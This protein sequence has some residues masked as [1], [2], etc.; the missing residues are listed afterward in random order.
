MN[1]AVRTEHGSAVVFDVEFVKEDNFSRTKAIR[2]TIIH[3]D[4]IKPHDNM[5]QEMYEHDLWE[6]M[7]GEGANDSPTMLF[8]ETNPALYIADVSRSS[9]CVEN[10]A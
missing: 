7:I 2:D 6:A 10:G 3:G 8:D 9:R 1:L 5:V 4:M